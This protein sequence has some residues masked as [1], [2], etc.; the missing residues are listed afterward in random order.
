MSFRAEIQMRWTDL[1]AQGHVNNV[2]VAD[3]LQQARAAF[4]LSGPAGPLLESGCVVVS[5]SIEYLR[6]ISWSTEPLVVELSVSGL[7]G[8]RLEISYLLNQGAELVGRARSVL[9]PFDF[10][11]QTPRRL[12]GDERAFFTSF[13]AEGFELREL[14]ACALAG[15][16]YPYDVYP[17][18][19]DPDRYGHVNNIRFLDFVVAG[20]VAMTTHA[21]PSM[22]RSGMTTE[23]G[24]SDKAGR[25]WL[26]ARQDID[27]IGQ[28]SFRMQPYRVLTAPVKIGNSS[29]VLATEIIDHLAG[30][31]LL[32]SARS[33]LVAA[34][35]QGNK[36]PLGE[37]TTQAL[38]AYLV[39]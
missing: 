29:L 10:A 7:G 14:N 11:R 28:M 38:G 24:S 30:G 18:W 16:G 37:H 2:V 36:V 32:A 9:C 21:D 20:R 13:L 23:Q 26:I 39:S 27:Y 5:H 17:R 3:Y 1:D 12:T 35:E 8:A 22:A 19:S 33:V 4:M 34:D 15:R 6:P 25:R 31:R